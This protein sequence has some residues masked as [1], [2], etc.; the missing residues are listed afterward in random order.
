MEFVAGFTCANDLSDRAATFRSQMK[1]GSPFHADWTGHK[2]FDGACPLGPWLVPAKFVAD[3]MDLPIILS[4]NGEVR[5]QSN[6]RRM[7]FSIAEQI[8]AL[9]SR[10][11]LHPGDVVLT[12]TPAGVGMARGVFLQPG[13]EMRVEIGS[14]GVLANTVSKPSAA[15]A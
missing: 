13:D 9:S 6:T 10:I 4:V 5:Q 14:I 1:P 11:T 2:S 3:P 15:A 7:V 8:A 12:G